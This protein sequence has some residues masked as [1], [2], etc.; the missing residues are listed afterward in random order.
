MYHCY[1]QYQQ[2]DTV[3]SRGRGLLQR[4]GLALSKRYTLMGSARITVRTSGCAPLA[5]PAVSREELIMLLVTIPIAS[6]GIG[7]ESR[8]GG[9]E[10]DD[11]AVRKEFSA[12]A[13]LLG[14]MLLHAP[15]GC[16]PWKSSVAWKKRV[17]GSWC[18]LVGNESAA[19]T[20]RRLG[21]SCP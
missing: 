4:A 13:S 6:R 18:H 14:L 11:G 2:N 17:E 21:D 9:G 20:G 16:H 12:Q 1:C 7:L 3:V 8:G 19:S 15:F 5:A 10:E